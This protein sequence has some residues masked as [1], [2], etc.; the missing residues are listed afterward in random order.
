MGSESMLQIRGFAPESKERGLEP[1]KRERVLQC[2]HTRIRT[3]GFS[4]GLSHPGS[5]DD[6][7]GGLTAPQARNETSGPGGVCGVLL[8]KMCCHHALL[9]GGEPVPY[10]MERHDPKKEYP[11]VEIQGEAQGNAADPR[12][13]HGMA[14]P[15]ER[16]HGAEPVLH[17]PASQDVHSP[18]M[19]AQPHADHCCPEAFHQR[20]VREHR[21]M[22][23]PYPIPCR[24]RIHLSRN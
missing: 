1:R 24:K 11:G 17:P 7:P 19:Q 14:E 10:G 15:F 3:G 4:K 2:G 8:R 16:T 5:G 12:G 23:E 18:K 13:I 21:R 9:A 22:T 20:P 6:G